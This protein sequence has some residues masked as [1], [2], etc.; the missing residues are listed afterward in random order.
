[1][2]GLVEVATWL[3]FKVGFAEVVIRHFTDGYEA[4]AGES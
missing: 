4:R 1:M 3:R 2:V